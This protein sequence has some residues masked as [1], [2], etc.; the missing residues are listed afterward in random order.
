VGHPPCRPEGRRHTARRYG[1]TQA[2]ARR[3]GHPLPRTR[4]TV[5]RQARGQAHI[6]VVCATKTEGKILRSRRTQR[7]EDLSY[8]TGRTADARVQAGTQGSV[9]N[10]ALTGSAQARVPVLLTASKS[11]HPRRRKTARV[12][13]RGLELK[14]P[15]CLSHRMIVGGEKRTTSCLFREPGKE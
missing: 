9:G 13:H 7:A 14:L 2:Q 6:E 3:L 12:R 11:V 4:R 1:E 15:H 10:P 5:P 8:N